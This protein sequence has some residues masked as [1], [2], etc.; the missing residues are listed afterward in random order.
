VGFIGMAIAVGLR[1]FVLPLMLLV[2]GAKFGEAAKL[3][4]VLALAIP[5]DFMAA[6]C[7]TV[8]V[9]SGRDI[10]VAVGM[11]IGVVINFALNLAWIPHYGAMGAARA[12]V[13]S[14]VVVVCA[15]S[16]SLFLSMPPRLVAALPNAS[17]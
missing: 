15:L 5:F 3:L 14:Y 10:V 9:S 2:F 4:G 16:L 13:I 11:L 17:D 8:L 12:T 1:H 6:M 7:A